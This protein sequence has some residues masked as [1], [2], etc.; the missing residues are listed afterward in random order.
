[1]KTPLRITLGIFAVLL[2][3][4][5]AAC[6]MAGLGW[7]YFSW[8]VGRPS[9]AEQHLISHRSSLS[10]DRDQLLETFRGTSHAQTV[11]PTALPASLCAPGVQFALIHSDHITLITYSSPDTQSGFRVWKSAMG[12]GFADGPTAIPFVTRF[13]Y[14]DDYP[15]SASN[16]LE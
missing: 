3:L 5:V 15:D 7:L 6:V 13:T 1:M 4:A 9:A 14:C 12:N 16:R 8:P 10:Q 11:K 2:A